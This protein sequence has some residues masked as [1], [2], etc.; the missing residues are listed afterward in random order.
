[1]TT[2]TKTPHPHAALMA[3]YA[4][5]AAETDTPWERWQVRAVEADWIDLTGSPGWSP[6][7]EYRR[8]PATSAFPEPEPKPTACVGSASCS[9]NTA[10]KE[11]EMTTKKIYGPSIKWHGGDCPVPPETMVEVKFRCGVLGR[12]K[13]AGSYHWNHFDEGGDIVEYRTFT[14]QRDRDLDAAEQL[15]RA[16]GYTVTKPLTFEDVVPMT[17]I[18]PEGTEFWVIAATSEEGAYRTCWVD[19]NELDLRT[20]KRRMAYLD[21]EHA[22]IAARHIF[23][24]KGG[25]L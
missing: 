15:L 10:R 13:R 2:E 8:K 22:L 24:L 21:E 9:G 17:E 11:I 5:D 3:Q 20:L 4:A 16:N 7:F 14:E 1:M 25:E 6:V 23:G 18:P 12:E 19:G